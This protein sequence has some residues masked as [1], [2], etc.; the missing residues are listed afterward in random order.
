MKTVRADFSLS[1]IQ[2]E[3]L[4]F[5]KERKLR[6]LFLK[7]FLSFFFMDNHITEVLWF[8]TQVV[9]S[10]SLFFDNI[11]DN[12]MC[13]AFFRFWTN[14]LKKEAIKLVVEHPLLS[15]WPFIQ[16]SKIKWPTTGLQKLCSDLWLNRMNDLWRTASP[17]KDCWA[18]R[19]ES[20]DVYV[21]RGASGWECLAG[22]LRE[23]GRYTLTLP[24]G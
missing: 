1:L 20:H 5:T 19:L 4:T 22:I 24:H 11:I 8:Q 3:Q 13:Q 9:F 16:I 21:L 14:Y 18:I 10:L 23:N 12:T 7:T 6:S 2:W 15:Q 17:E